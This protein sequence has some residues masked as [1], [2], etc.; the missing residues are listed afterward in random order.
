MG[1]DEQQIRCTGWLFAMSLRCKVAA[2]HLKSMHGSGPRC[3]DGEAQAQLP[4]PRPCDGVNAGI[5]GARI[6]VRHAISL[7]HSQR[8]RMLG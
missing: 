2:P 7:L 4:T 6:I 1:R 3:T 8:A 5:S